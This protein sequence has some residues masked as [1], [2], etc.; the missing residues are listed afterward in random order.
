MKFILSFFEGTLWFD[1]SMHLKV[2]YF[3]IICVFYQ[4]IYGWKRI[5]IFRICFVDVGVINAHPPFNIWIF[6]MM[7]LVN[8]VVCVTSFIKSPFKSFLTSWSRTYYHSSLG[9]LIFGATNLAFGMMAK[10]WHIK[11][12]SISNMSVALHAKKL[13]FLVKI[14]FSFLCMKRLIT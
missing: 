12:I 14:S 4:E 11:S 7:T 8:H 6:T 10:L 1:C 3:E 9:F 13:E 5:I 2:K